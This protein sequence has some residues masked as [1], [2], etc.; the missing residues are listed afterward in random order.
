[1][2]ISSAAA[3]DGLVNMTLSWPTV[4][5]AKSYELM[6]THKGYMWLNA[7]ATVSVIFLQRLPVLALS[8]SA[9]RGDTDR[10]QSLITLLSESEL[11]ALLSLSLILTA[12]LFS[13]CR[14]SPTWSVQG[15][16]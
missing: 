15:C 7:T 9:D 16:T 5:D 13:L 10:P 8:C 11:P 14:S 2:R 3:V 12:T 4:P 6:L 1:M